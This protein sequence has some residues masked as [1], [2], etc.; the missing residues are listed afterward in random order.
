MA[1]ITKMMILAT[2]RKSWKRVMGP[3][4]LAAA[5]DKTRLAA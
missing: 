1:R 5:L 4:A 2:V 3:P